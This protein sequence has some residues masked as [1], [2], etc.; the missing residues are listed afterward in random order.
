LT[1]RSGEILALVGENGA[2]KSTLLK[3]LGGIIQPNE[4]E[5]LVDGMPRRLR[6]VRDAISLGIALIHQELNLAPDVSVAENLFLGRYPCRGP[7]WLQLTDRRRLN[8]LA[9][10]ELQRI[11]LD[12]SPHE[13]LGRL[14]LAQ[15][16]LVEI[17]KALATHARLLV[18]DEPTSSLTLQEADKL[19]VIIEELRS[20]GV[21]IVYVSHRLHEVERLADR[22]VVLRDGRRIIELP[23]A[24][25][26]SQRMISH[27]VGRDLQAA[28][29][30]TRGQ[31]DDQP[32]LSV[33]NLRLGP[34]S[35]AINF[36]IQPGEIVGL[37][38]IIGAGR[39]ELA[40]ALFGIAPPATGKIYIDGTPVAARTPR[41][42]VEAGLALVP[43]D[44]KALGV[45][46]EMSVRSNVSLAVLDCF[47]PYGW[48]NRRAESALAEQFCQALRIR[49]SHPDVT[50]GSLSGGNQQKVALAKWLA[51]RPKV[52]ILDEPT[53]GVDMA[54]KQ[55]IYRIV[56]QQAAQGTAILLISSELEE[57]IALADRVLV[58]H[59]R[60]LA[61]ELQGTDISEDNMMRLALGMETSARTPGSCTK[62]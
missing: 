60:R 41:E 13:P 49:C 18:L 62:S 28:A 15:R 54:A 5:M 22:A 37:A 1:L 44:R 7:R 6:S 51:A 2:G 42:A 19:F 58:M 50:T 57:I 46:L 8:R 38:G 33:S 30:R 14:S 3:I 47:A 48:Y 16:Q 31:F 56:Q 20:Q 10:E 61:G 27:M 55:E 43:E 29:K 40:R 39:T 59:Q 25:I 53:R 35:P 17:A 9:C 36:A 32:R 11:G 21:G 4:G 26:S 24:E 12:V 34:S 45:I 23:R 52:L